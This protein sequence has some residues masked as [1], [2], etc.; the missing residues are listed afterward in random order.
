METE[1]KITCT[2]S[3]CGEQE[4]IFLPQIITEEHRAQTEDLSLFKWTCPQCGHV[5]K[6]LYPCMYLNKGKKLLIWYVNELQD[7]ERLED[8]LSQEFKRETR[9]YAKRFCHTLEEF[10]EKVRV[11]EQGLDDR[12]IEL[13]K[14]MTFARLH[15]SDKSLEHIYFYREDEIGNFEFTLFYSEGP[16]GIK[17]NGSM[18]QEIDAV[19]KEKLMTLQDHFYCIDLDWAGKQIVQM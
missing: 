6:L 7:T 15:V 5:L 17:L 19:V 9:G 4:T 13:L 16:K 8:E 2:C 3:K 18:Y 12:T 10:G 1:K 14:I 11:L